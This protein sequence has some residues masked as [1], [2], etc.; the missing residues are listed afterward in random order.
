MLVL[1]LLPKPLYT[2]AVVFGQTLNRSI[3][4]PWVCPDVIIALG[5][6][7]RAWLSVKDV[8]LKIY[9]AHR[10]NCLE[11]KILGELPIKFLAQAKSYP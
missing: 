4:S 9:F 5:T 11:K 1:T 3:E 6:G 8:Q 7:Y 2:W 10:S